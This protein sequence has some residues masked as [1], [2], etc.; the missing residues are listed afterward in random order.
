MTHGPMDNW[1]GADLT[2]ESLY[3]AI[4]RIEQWE[5][6]EVLLRPAGL[7]VPTCYARVMRREMGKRLLRRLGSYGLYEWEGERRWERADWP[8]AQYCWPR[9]VGHIET[10]V[11]NNRHW[12]RR[13]WPAMMNDQEFREAVERARCSTDRTTGG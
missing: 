6:E 8:L 12:R 13:G 1:Q 11:V 2:P 3:R 10:Y 7:V 9:E 5:Q 4:Q